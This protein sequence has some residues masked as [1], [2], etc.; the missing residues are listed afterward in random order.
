MSVAVASSP[1]KVILFGEHG[2]HRQQ[3]N[4]TT[5]VNLHTFCKVSRRADDGYS[6]RSGARHEQGSRDDLAQFKRHVDGLRESKA[7]DDIAALIRRDFY[8]PGRYVMSHLVSRFDGPGL[9]VEWHSHLPVGSGLG[10]GAAASSSM[11]LASG[12]ALNHAITPD[13]VIFLAWQGDAIAHGGYGSS[14]DSSTCV[15]GGYIIYSLED[16]GKRL[17]FD[18]TLPIVIGDT[19]V[20]HRTNEVNTHIRKWLAENPTRLHVFRDMGYLRQ[21]FLEALEQAD[22]EALGHIMNLHQLLQV[23]MGTSIPESDRLIEAAIGAG[24][25]GAKISGSGGGGIIIAVSAPDKQADIAVAINAAGGRAY[26]VQAGIQGARLEAPDA[27][28]S[29]IQHQQTQD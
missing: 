5:T 19:L 11:V 26:V 24:A 27:W 15:L 12:A 6:F 3:P 25:Y 29:A 4:I 18:V 17:P 28:D 7:L 23:K 13:D 16:K 2:V 21:P 10:S 9:D 22:F 1:G 8:A 14:L 20:E